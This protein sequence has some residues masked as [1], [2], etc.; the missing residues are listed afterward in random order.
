MI[1]IIKNN[2]LDRLFEWLIKRLFKPNEIANRFKLPSNI[3]YL[4]G[5]K[6]SSLVREIIAN[7]IKKE[8][9][10]IEDGFIRSVNYGDID[11]TYSISVD[12]KNIYYD[13]SSTNN[14]E[15]H[16]VQKLDKDK[17][18]RANKLKKLWIK[19]RISKYNCK[20]DSEI[21]KEPFIL[22]VDQTAK[23]CSIKYGSA[24]NKSFTKML[25]WAI[26]KWPKHTILIK[27]HPD[28]IHGGK[29]SH[30][31]I[32]V[33]EKQGIK[34][35]IDGGHPTSLLE[36]CD[37]VCVVTSQLGFEAL[38]WDK[39]VY[40]F[41]WPFYAGW[42]LTNDILGKLERRNIHSIKIEQLIH[43]VLIDYCRYIHPETKEL[44][45]PEELIDWIKSQRELQKKLPTKSIG[46]GFT[47]WKASQVKRYLPN[48]RFRPRINTLKNK[49]NKII[50]W[51]KKRI[52]KNNLG[53]DSIIRVEDGFIRSVGLGANLIE[54]S[55]LIFD[56]KG[57]YYDGENLSDLEDTLNKIKITPEEKLRANKLLESLVKLK[58]TK[59]NLKGKDW[60]AKKKNK[61]KEIILALGQVES[62]ASI[63]FGIPPDSNINSNLELIKVTRETFPKSYLIY[64]PHPDV[65]KLLRKKGKNDNRIREYCDEI[66]DDICIEK[67][68]KKIDRLSVMTSLGGFEGLIRGI[69]VTTWGIPFYAG[70][71]LTDD[72]LKE[73]E[74]IKKK[75]NRVL[76]LEELIYG[77]LINYPLYISKLSGRLCSPEQAIKELLIVKE[78]KDQRLN[79]KQLTF[80]IWGS[81]IDH[82]L[83]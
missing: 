77:C 37:A 22:L 50:V 64:K 5:K 58:I 41:G 19:N 69:P 40:V 27:I 43:A 2:N 75:R 12:T 21:P 56:K 68:Y 28:V 73:H 59:Y 83:N 44:C 48:I 76:S 65:A 74:W 45:Q 38:L 49:K 67:M 55:S 36:K 78:Q 20:V 80:R 63:K 66:V 9:V 42:G 71:G 34:F 17:I 61:N 29:R 23:D 54:S 16:I 51:G 11:E 33:L 26:E 57:I 47:P 39:P 3:I 46:I 25:S 35:S 79:M 6:N 60:D 53:V 24:T 70:W 4:W 8:K 52:E 14:L 7:L 15:N 62:D 32:K 18:N 1:K 82:V 13:Y 72:K 30:F 81:L 10:Y 31:N